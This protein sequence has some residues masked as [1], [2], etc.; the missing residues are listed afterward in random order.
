VD[1]VFQLLKP[2][3]PAEGVTTKIGSVTV[4]KESLGSDECDRD[5]SLIEPSNVNVFA[6]LKNGQADL[7]RIADAASDAAVSVLNQ[8]T[9]LPRRLAVTEKSLLDVD[10]CTL[11]DAST[12]T[13]VGVDGSAPAPEYGSW[14]CRWGAAGVRSAKVS[15]DQGPPL[16]SSRDGN[17]IKLGRWNAFV[18]PNGMTTGTTASW[19]S[20]TTTS[21]ATARTRS[22]RFAWC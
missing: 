2:G 21:R 15:F 16:T 12:L 3:P 1:V 20:S 11:L 22:R 18:L 6:R 4:T 8:G 9:L 5:L 17:P 19:R 13:G 7:C 10:A 14:E